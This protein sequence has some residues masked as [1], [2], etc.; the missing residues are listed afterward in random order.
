[1][2]SGRR[3]DALF[4]VFFGKFNVS[5]GITLFSFILY[6]PYIIFLSMIATSLVIYGFS[7]LE[8]IYLDIY[9]SSI[10]SYVIFM[11]FFGSISAY[12]KL[13]KKLIICD[14]TTKKIDF[15]FFEGALFFFSIVSLMLFKFKILN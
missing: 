8:T 15:R 12:N 14:N 1:M 5:I 3:V 13:T 10:V 6:F 4:V 9:F 7:S 11:V 2:A